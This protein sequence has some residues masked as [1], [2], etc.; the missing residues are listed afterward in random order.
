MP[1]F[2]LLDKAGPQ[3]PHLLLASDRFEQTPAPSE[4]EAVR[5]GA[6]PGRVPDL[7]PP[8]D[9]AVS[10]SGTPRLDAEP[11]PQAP[12][13]G[14]ALVPQVAGLGLVARRDTVVSVDLRASGRSMMHLGVCVCERMYLGGAHL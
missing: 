12:L 4:A 6:G 8:R 7:L 11:C 13:R 3:A 5:E 10:L 1:E 9:R 14:R 2:A